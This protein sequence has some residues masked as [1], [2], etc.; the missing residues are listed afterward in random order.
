MKIAS[1]NVNS[2]NV[3]L[4]HLLE[5]LK[6]NPVDVLGLQEIKMEDHKFP[7]ETLKEAGFN[8]VFAGQK[9]YNG[10][11]ILSPHAIQ[12][13]EINLPHFED[14]AQRLI[15]ASVGDVRFICVYVPNGSDVESEKFIYKQNWLTAFVDYL[16][17]QK[18]Q[19]EKIVI[20][21]DFNIAPTSLDVFDEEA[22]F[23]QIC[24]TKTERAFFQEIVDLGFVDSFRQI[25]EKGGHFSW[26]DYRQGSFLQNK[27]LRIDFLLSNF[28]IC[29]AGID[30]APRKWNRPSD[31]AP[32]WM[33][34]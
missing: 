30:Q 8:A 5:W 21:G 28:A 16:K 6:N 22:C 1:W 20:G 32:V 11:A 12:N 26:W 17:A 24:C 23:N 31:H 19:F 25:E 4:A 15:T 14:S 29:Q 33:E 10:V 27:G 13:V 18:T 9:S 2:L 7:L 3:R 34:Y